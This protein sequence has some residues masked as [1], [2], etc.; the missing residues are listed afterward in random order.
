[1]GASISREFKSSP[2][3]VETN[4][5]IYHYYVDPR[6][7]INAGS[8]ISVRPWESFDPHRINRP[9][10][11]DRVQEIIDYQEEFY[12]RTGRYD[13]SDDKIIMSLRDDKLQILDGQHR[14]SAI[15]NLANEAKIDI[16]VRLCE[17]EDEEFAIFAKINK[18]ESVPQMYMDRN[19]IT[20]RIIQ[21]YIDA[22]DKRFPHCINRDKRAKR[23]RI[24]AR[25][26]SDY[27]YRE[28][29]LEE[30][31]L[32]DVTPE[33]A[34]RVLVNLTVA[35][36]EEYLNKSSCYMPNYTGNKKTTVS[37]Y[38]TGK[39]LGFMLGMM[40]NFEWLDEIVEESRTD[41]N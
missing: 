22:L 37:C 39:H 21:E 32:F 9:V 5:D 7:F 4:P 19:K 36:N 6:D 1:M 40:K 29:V 26:L 11:D 13:F 14:Y 23:P 24:D 38:N 16:V 34:I 2:V 31:K 3:R 20:K 27:I 25:Q 28:N 30:M 41:N 35:K 17:T 12:E 15:L 8:R 18:S 10:D 33:E